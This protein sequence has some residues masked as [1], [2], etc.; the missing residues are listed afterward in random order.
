MD[1]PYTGLTASVKLGSHSTAILLGYVSGVDL[2]L[3][4][5]IIE[6]LAFGMT[7]KK[8]LPAIKDWSMSIDGTLALATGNTQKQLYDA[9]ESGAELVFGIY[10]DDNNYF[11]GSG[12]VSSFGISAAP[13][14]KIGL[15]AEVAGSGAVVLTVGGVTP[16]GVLNLSSSDGLATGY[17]E[18]GVSEGLAALHHFVYKTAAT[19]TMPAYDDALTAGWTAWDGNDAILA[20][21]GNELVVAEILTA[22]NKAKRA[23]KVIVDS[24]DA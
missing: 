4:K 9:F 8:K 23:G 14:D 20:T 7:Y 6:I 11:E 22:D 19:V 12:L 16:L 1:T 18:I 10:L 15:T 24:N 5:E 17:T 2:S 13:D 21:T 3:E